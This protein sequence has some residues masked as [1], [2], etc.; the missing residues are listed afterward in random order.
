VLLIK[1]VWFANGVKLEEDGAGEGSV[2]DSEEEEKGKR[3]VSV[4]TG[5]AAVVVVGPAPMQEQALS[6]RYDTSP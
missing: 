1:L 6:K 3:T 2:L 4:T 5:T